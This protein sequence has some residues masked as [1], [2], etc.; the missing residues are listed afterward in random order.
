MAGGERSLIA[1]L[2]DVLRPA[3]TGRGARCAG[4]ATTP[5]SCARGPCAVTSDRHDGRRRPLPPRRPARRPG[6]RRPPRAGRRAVATSPRWAPSPARPTSRWALPPGLRRGRRAR[7]RRARWR[8]SRRDCGVDDRRRRRHRARRPDGRGHRRRLGRA[9]RT[10]SSAATA[11][12]RATSSASPGR[13]A[14]SAAGP[15]P[16]RRPARP[17]PPPTAAWR[18]T[19]APAAA[20]R[21]PR[22]RAGGRPRDDRPLRRPRHR[23][24]RTSPRVSGVR[25]ELDLDARWP[26]RR[27]AAL[28]ADAASSPRPAA[29]TTSC[30]PACRPSGRRRRPRPPG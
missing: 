23:R 17:A 11:R 4:W 19:C 26:R 12:A 20:G 3:A 1:A 5:R 10:T 21:G 9:P 13:S 24:R 2:E 22:A 7:A 15:A 27:R 6:R 8:R 30:A 14:R 29:R 18:A 28:R 25:L 16:S